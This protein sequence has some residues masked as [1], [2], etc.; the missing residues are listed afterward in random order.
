MKKIHI[1]LLIFT[2]F[3]INSCE[4]VV[5]T[6]L[7]TAPP[8]LVID[9]SINWEKG[10]LG[11]NQYIRLSTTT[12]F[13]ENEIPDVTGAVVF[14]ENNNGDIFEFREEA[15]GLYVCNNFVCEIGET[16]TLTVINNSETY[17]AE[18]TLIAVPELE[19]VVQSN[20]GFTPNDITLRAYFQDPPEDNFYMQEIGR[21]GYLGGGAVFDDRF[22]NGNYTYTVRIFD[23]L[24]TGEEIIIYLYGISSRYYDYMLK[25][26]SITGDAEVNPFRPPPGTVRGNIINKNNPDNYALG[27][28]RL[29]EVSSIEYTAQ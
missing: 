10:T 24:V 19:E 4:D 8:R 13:Y 26:L 11:N 21:E 5:E 6:N 17:I 1:L 15:D 22:V 14:V 29:S 7:T 27:Y 16:Y 28:F 18:E 12:G 25:L 2:G 20:E 3:I 9:A 23:D